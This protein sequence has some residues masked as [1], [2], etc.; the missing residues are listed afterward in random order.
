MNNL[1]RYVPIALI[2]G[3]FLYANFSGPSAVEDDID[4][5]QVLEVTVET[6]SA[7]EK[8]N[9]LLVAEQETNQDG[10]FVK[11]SQDLAANYNAAIPAIFDQPITVAPQQDASL[12]AFVDADAS[13]AFDSG[14]EALYMIEVDGENSRVIA[15]GRSGAVNDSRISGS[16][17][18]TGM[19]IGSMLSRQRASGS[20]P[21]SKKT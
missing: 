10:A 13:G 14:E 2:A 15:T 5:N 12:I 9:P 16:G 1:I 20:S 6:I 3:Y 11:F 17:L 4:L 7:F 18:L 21:A 8:N 19:L